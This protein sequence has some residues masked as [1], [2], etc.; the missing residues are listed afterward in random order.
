MD[1]DIF[2]HQICCRCL[3]TANSVVSQPSPSVLSKINNLAAL[4]QLDI[5][6]LAAP[7]TGEM[8]EEAP[9]SAANR[10]ISEVVRSRRRPLLGPSPG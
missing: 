5:H 2:S 6:G 10:L 8:H 9:S 3:I 7:H 1:G 4:L